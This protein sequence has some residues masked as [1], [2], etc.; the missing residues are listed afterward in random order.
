[1]NGTSTEQQ[2]TIAEK[3]NETTSKQTIHKILIPMKTT[4]AQKK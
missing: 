4:I 1:M 3:N 2:E